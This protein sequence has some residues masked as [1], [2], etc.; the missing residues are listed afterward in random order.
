MQRVRVMIA[1]AALLHGAAV[2]RAQPAGGDE[3]ELGE[4]K[5]PPKPADKPAE[6]TDAPVQK[7]PKLAKKVFASGQQAQAKGDAFAKRNKPDDAKAQYE[8]AATSYAK[9][10]ELGDDINV[11]FHLAV[12]LDK[13]GK[14]ADAIHHLRIVQKATAGVTP[15]IQKQLAGKLDDLMGKVGTLALAITP[16]GTTITIEGQ[17]VGTTPLAEPLVLMP[18]SYTLALA[19]PGFEPKSIDVKVEAG[20]ESERKVELESVKIV[21]EKPRPVKPDEPEKVAWTKPSLVPAI[22]AG[23]AAVAFLTVEIV[24]GL[25][26][27]KNHDTF[28]NPATSPTGRLDAQ[29]TGRSYAHLSDACL[30]GAVVSAGFGAY[31]YIF[32]YRKKIRDHESNVPDKTALRP[33]LDVVPWV[34]PQASGVTV[35]GRF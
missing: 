3:I 34:E 23:G 25:A 11:H 28:V 32:Q 1:A 12:T 6:P 18:G 5:A 8:L 4:E 17:V 2:A 19:A 7:D 22:A 21:I 27:R 13:L 33:K 16:E 29:D 15:A 30:A 14:P 31:W 24:A 35:L 20:S 9:A 26:A 10:I